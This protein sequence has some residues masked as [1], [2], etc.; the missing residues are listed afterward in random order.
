MRTCFTRSDRMSAGVDSTA[1][2]TAAAARWC[3]WQSSGA[4]ERADVERRI[5]WVRTPRLR[6]LLVALALATRVILSPPGLAVAMLGSRRSP[7]TPGYSPT[8]IVGD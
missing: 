8:V 2:D 3:D 4:L 6:P 7:E 5:S 1:P